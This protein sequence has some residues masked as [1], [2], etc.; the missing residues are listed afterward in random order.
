MKKLMFLS[1]CLQL[2]TATLHAQGRYEY[3]VDGDI[4]ARQQGTYED[5]TLVSRID[6]SACADGIH[7]LSFRVSG[8]DGLW[9]SPG[10]VYFLKRRHLTGNTI[11]GYVYWIDDDVED[12][13]VVKNSDGVLRLDINAAALPLGIHSVRAYAFDKYGNKSCPVTSVFVNR[14]K[15]F[16]DNKILVMEYWV[17]DGIDNRHTVSLDTD[18]PILNLES[19]IP[20]DGANR[21]CTNTLYYRFMDSNGMWSS[22]QAAVFE[23]KGGSSVING[24]YISGGLLKIV[25]RRVFIDNLREASVTVYDMSGKEIFGKSDVNGQVSVSLRQSGVY[26]VRIGN[27]GCA[28]SVR[29]VLVL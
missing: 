16:A 27:A 9:S 3:W 18:S 11:A 23:F 12:R 1:F 15:Y 26:L 5:G 2:L 29:R 6:M 25:D 19:D 22:L 21:E 4:A 10:N 14:G 24:S 17:N 7:Q 20:V 8:K 28:V 13:K